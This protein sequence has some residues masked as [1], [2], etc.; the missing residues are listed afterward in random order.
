MINVWL[1]AS[2]WWWWWWLL[3]FGVNMMGPFDDQGL[4]N[5]LFKCRG[6]RPPDWGLGNWV[7]PLVRVVVVLDKSIPANSKEVLTVFLADSPL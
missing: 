1:M 7:L 5:I 2:K 4:S 3:I 6:S